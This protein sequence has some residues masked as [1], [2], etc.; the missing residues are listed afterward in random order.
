M[1]DLVTISGSDTLVINDRVI[2][3]LA[4]DDVSVIAFTENLANVKVGKNGNALYAKSEAG[5]SA[6][7]TLRLSKGSS[8]DRFLHEQLAGMN[9]NFASFGLVAGTFN[10]VLGDENGAVINENYTLKGGVFTKHV[11]SKDNV[12]GDTAQAVSIYV[13]KFAKAIRGIG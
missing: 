6:E 9:E 12:S 11:E 8:D 4:D 5:N 13:L 2:N 7:L 10:K 3:D 1:S